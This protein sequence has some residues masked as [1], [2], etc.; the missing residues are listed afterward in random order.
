MASREQHGTE[1][2]NTETLSH[3]RAPRRCRSQKQWVFEMKFATSPLSSCSQTHST[4]NELCAAHQQTTLTNTALGY[5]QTRTTL[6]TSGLGQYGRPAGLLK[7]PRD[8]TDG[9]ITMIMRKKCTKKQ[10][11]LKSLEESLTPTP[12]CQ[13]AFHYRRY[14]DSL[15]LGDAVI[16]RPT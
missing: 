3:K 4:F 13:C 12:I 1:G 5:F 7:S 6:T 11:I 14:T 9:I 10:G 16:H 8:W 2:I 15:G